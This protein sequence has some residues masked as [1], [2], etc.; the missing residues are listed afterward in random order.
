MV[1]SLLFIIKVIIFIAYSIECWLNY[2]INTYHDHICI[3]EILYPYC[4]Y[5]NYYDDLWFQVNSELYTG[6]LDSW[7]NGHHFVNT[8]KI[9]NTLEQMDVLNASYNMFVMITILSI[10]K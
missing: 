7:G 10:G 3:F 4:D 2:P 1:S 5:Y 9:I 8:K 6:W